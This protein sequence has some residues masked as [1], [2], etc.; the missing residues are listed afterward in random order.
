MSLGYIICN[1]VINT[2]ILGKAGVTSG[3]ELQT[4]SLVW[5]GLFPIVIWAKQ[6][7]NNFRSIPRLSKCVDLVGSQSS[8][9]G[10]RN[11]IIWNRG[12]QERP[13]GDKSEVL[14]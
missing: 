13:C 5:E 11:I 9:R 8:P 7:R 1:F 3:K 14:L 10:R 2:L 4:T 12:R 6:F